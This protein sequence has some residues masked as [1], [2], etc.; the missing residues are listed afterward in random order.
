VRYI[1]IEMLGAAPGM[2][3]EALDAELR[4]GE[5][6]L[7]VRL[8]NRGP[9][10]VRVHWGAATFRE[11]TGI[12]HSLIP[13]ARVAQFHM[14]SAM[15]QMS[16]QAYEGAGPLE[17]LAMFQASGHRILPVLE[18]QTRDMDLVIEPGQSVDE[19]LYPGS[20]HETEKIVR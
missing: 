18:Q 19:V 14:R 10:A 8:H 12:V 16:R 11:P 3:A 5:E 7:E 6:W 13:S 20:A 1:P 17:R 2:Q 9:S 15:M 4:I